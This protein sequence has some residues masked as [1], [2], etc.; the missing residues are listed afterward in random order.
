MILKL[1]YAVLRMNTLYHEI[2]HDKMVNFRTKLKPIK[3]NLVKIPLKAKL[4]K[5]D[6]RR[7]RNFE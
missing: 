5:F 1:S 4:T 2:I 6:I 3:K 7:N